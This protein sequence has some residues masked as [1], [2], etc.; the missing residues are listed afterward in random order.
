MLLVPLLKSKVKD[1]ANSSN[2]RPIA[3]ATVLSKVI[4]KVVLH[5]LEA[6]L[7][8]LDCQFSY[9]KGLG[10]EMCVWTLRNAIQYYTSRGSPVYL[11][12]LDASKAFDRVNYWKLF[13]KLIIR[14]TPGYLVKLLMFWYTTQEFCIKWGNSFSLP[15]KTANGIRPGGDSVSVSV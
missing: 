5:R 9:K 12:F 13:N 2:Y 6:Y 1:P 11:C 14:G 7:H 10:T 15:F 3:I 8:T 4:E